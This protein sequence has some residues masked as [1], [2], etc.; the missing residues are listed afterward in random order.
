MLRGMSN[1]LTSKRGA[2]L[3]MALML[4]LVCTTV[5]GVVIAAATAAVGRQSKYDDMDKRY[6]S[7]TSAASVFWDKLTARDENGDVRGVTVKVRR[8]CE[9]KLQSDGTFQEASSPNWQFTI[10][11]CNVSTDFKSSNSTLFELVAYD[12]VLGISESAS[13]TTVRSPSDAQ[14]KSSIAFDGTLPEAMLNGLPTSSKPRTY[15]DFTIEPPTSTKLNPVTVSTVVNEV[16]D[17]MFE[18]RDNTK[19]GYQLRLNTQADI[20]SRNVQQ[21]LTNAADNTYHLEWETTFAW[22]GVSLDQ[23]GGDAS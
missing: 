8:S 6:Y 2:S 22:R 16:G 4:L 23:A 20:D 7:T 19:G 15:Q 11:G 1:K 18:F 21:T 13:F 12:L 14:I 3:S 10:D 17:I 5:A 9:A